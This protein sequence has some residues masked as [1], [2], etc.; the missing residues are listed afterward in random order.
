MGK[1]NDYHV[2]FLEDAG[3][4]V[5]EVVLTAE[6][7]PIGSARAG[8]VAAEMHAVDFCVTVGRH[9]K[10]KDEPHPGNCSL[11]ANPVEVHRSTVSQQK[12]RALRWWSVFQP[13][14]P[15]SGIAPTK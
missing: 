2:R 1:L 4:S 13:F 11:G 8:E 5:A 10:F 14:Y 7:L 6:N 3:D 12:P 9:E 15:N